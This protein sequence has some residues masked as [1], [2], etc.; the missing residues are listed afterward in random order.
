V[1]LRPAE[2]EWL[3]E[4]HRFSLAELAELSGLPEAE[5]RELV[6]Y[7]CIAPVDP[8]SSQWA[9]TGKCLWTVRTASRIRVGFDLEPHGVALVVS[10]LD[11]INELEA[12][13]SSVRAQMPRRVRS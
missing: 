1:E 4:D 5:L 12:Q 9:F 11:R 13:L 3:S 6:D 7:G 8:D 2:T 10:L